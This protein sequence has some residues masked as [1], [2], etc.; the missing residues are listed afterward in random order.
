[1][2]KQLSRVTLFLIVVSLIISCFFAVNKKAYA[3]EGK[4]VPSTF[5]ESKYWYMGK[6]H[7]NLDGIRNEVEKLKT[8]LDKHK[9]E[10]ERNPIQI[11]VIDTGYNES[12]S[13][14]HPLWNSVYRT[15]SGIVGFNATAKDN[16]SET[17]KKNITDEVD[18]GTKVIN[19]ISLLLH[20]VGLSKYIKVVPIKAGTKDPEKVGSGVFDLASV[21]RAINWAGKRELDIVNMSFGTSDKR[22]LTDDNQSFS[23]EIEKYTNRT[24]FVS[25]AGNEGQ[26]QP[27]YPANSHED[28]MSVMSYREDGALFKS[29]YG[30]FSLMAPGDGIR[31]VNQENDIWDINATSAAT[32]IASF[33][34]SIVCL[35][36]KLQKLEAKQVN[37][38][39]DPEAIKNTVVGN[40]DEKKFSISGREFKFNKINAIKAIQNAQDTLGRPQ[41]L[42]IELDKSVKGAEI[43]RNKV[44]RR[45]LVSSE[46]KKENLKYEEL[47]SVIFRAVVSPQQ[48]PSVLKNIRWYYEIDKEDNWVPQLE[49]G[50]TKFHENKINIKAVKAVLEYEGQTFE[51]IVE[52]SITALTPNWEKF[53]GKVQEKKNGKLKKFSKAGYYIGE[54]VEMYASG[55]EG[56]DPEK[57]KWLV[58][59]KELN[60]T[61]AER[62]AFVTKKVK[63]HDI[64]LR[65]IDPRTGTEKVIDS[66]SIKVYNSVIPHWAIFIILLINLSAAGGVGFL[67]Y[68]LLTKRK[69]N[70][71][72]STSDAK[73]DNLEEETLQSEGTTSVENTSTSDIAKEN[74]NIDKTEDNNV[75]D[76][77]KEN[78]DTNQSDEDREMEELI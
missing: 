9:D 6:D 53:G 7:L 76:A 3:N 47:H 5:D 56:V 19:V 52:T 70:V 34:S 20:R 11:G 65:Y 14:S 63:K 36:L 12:T 37:T 17:E 71:A 64:E 60:K 69:A 45:T 16:A 73:E 61:E 15:A 18:H 38:M 27:F 4:Y 55:F 8:L 43:V 32:P 78:S 13:A 35:K 51:S 41:S 67:I 62:V 54:R 42:K 59:G 28:I 31:S 22:W 10:L 75:S 33:V 2:K 26:R 50:E 77:V 46:G 68:I 74:S 24:L 66:F 23:R 30:Y 40:A 57:V 39:V 48:P 72:T 58:D 25:S 49:V 44:D 1:M 29:N 21:I